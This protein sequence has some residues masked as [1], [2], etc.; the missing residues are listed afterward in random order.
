MNRPAK[1]SGTS[2]LELA[3]IIRLPMPRLE[4]TVSEITAPTKASV[5]AT[6]REAKKYGMEVVYKENFPNPISD[7]SSQLIKIKESKPDLII[8]GGY[9]A[10][11][12]L[13]AALEGFV[14][15]HAF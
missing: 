10:G 11:M 13:L 12:V 14:D 4:A 15:V 7:F 5:A 1:T 6:F 2:K 8:A 3:I 9:N